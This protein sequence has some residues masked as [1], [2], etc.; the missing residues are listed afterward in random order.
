MA[1]TAD[2]PMTQESVPV[3]EAPHEPATTVEAVPVER[4][5]RPL[6]PR[7]R[8]TGEPR[9]A[10]RRTRV[11]IR[12][13]G[14][15]S[16]FK[17]SLL[18]YFCAMLILFFALLMIF[19]VLQAAGTID[20]LENTIGCLVQEGERPTTGECIPYLIDGVTVF[21]WMFF[22][23][24]VGTVVVAALNTFVALIYNL[25]SDIVGGVEVTLAEKRVREPGTLGVGEAARREV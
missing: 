22:L 1:Q 9:A 10:R 14:A 16:V 17:F 4:P 8:P 7:A 25:I 21:T 18:F 20:T 5:R 15:L 24:C 2:N 3:T 19:L 12:R 23:G 11:E 6:P 13:V